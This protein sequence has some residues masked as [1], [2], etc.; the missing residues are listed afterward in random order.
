MYEAIKDRA[1]APSPLELEIA[2]GKRRLDDPA[3]IG[4]F[5]NMPGFDTTDALPVCL[6]V[7]VWASY[8]DQRVR[9]ASFDKESWEEYLV[10][11]MIIADL[12]FTFVEVP[13]FR[14]FVQYT[15]GPATIHIPSADTVKRRVVA[16]SE[17]TVNEIREYFKVRCFL[18]E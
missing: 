7:R 15:R 8:A 17:K 5:A 2:E 3:V 14:D 4:Y 12:P 6:D 11:F 9:Q 18:Y 16:L 10:K 13:E 1:E